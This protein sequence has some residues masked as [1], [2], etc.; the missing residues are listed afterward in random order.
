MHILVTG[1]HGFIGKALCKKIPVQDWRVRGTV[2]NSKHLTN[3]AV[4]SD[5]VV[6]AS[7]ALQFK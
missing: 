6:V 2:R 4:P 7:N 3:L 1:A 5:G